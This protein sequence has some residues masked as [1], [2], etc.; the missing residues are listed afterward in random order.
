MDTGLLQVGWRILVFYKSDTEIR[1][2]VLVCYKRDTEVRVWI[3]VFYQKVILK[4]E[5]R[6]R[7]ITKVILK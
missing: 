5:G 1:A 7:S 4:S 3:L 2:S 6:Y